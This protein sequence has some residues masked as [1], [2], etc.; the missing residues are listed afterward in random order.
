MELISESSSVT[1]LHTHGLHV[2]PSGR[3]DNVMLKINPGKQNTYTIDLPKEHA[4][5][6]H[7]YHAHLH[8][9]TAVQVQGGMA[10][11]LIVD[12]LVPAEGLNPPG[13]RVQERVMV[14]QFGA[15]WNKEED[16]AGCQ[17]L[18]AA[19]AAQLTP[20][21]QSRVE[22]LVNVESAEGLLT[23]ANQIDEA[24]LQSL[25]QSLTR[26]QAT[27]PAML[28][29][30]VENPVLEVQQD[31]AV[32]RLR[33]VNAGSRRQDY[34]S[35]WIE[36][37][38]DPDVSL[39]MYVGAFDGVNLTSLPKKDGKY[40]AYTKENRLDLAPG[41]RADIFV[42]PDSSGSFTLMMEGEV[43]VRDVAETAEM[44]AESLPLSRERSV[45]KRLKF[46]RSLLTFDIGGA[47]L[48]DN[49]A[50]EAVGQVVE[51]EAFLDALNAHLIALQNEMPAYHDGYLR[52]F[53]DGQEYIKR[54][55]RFDVDERAFLINDRSYNAE[56]PEMAGSHG[57]DLHKQ[58]AGHSD[59]LGKVEGDGGLGP[60]GEKPWPLRTGT[61][62]EWVIVN[63]ST[64]PHPFHIHVSPFWVLD[65]ME[66]EGD[67]LISVLETNPQDPRLNRWQDTINLPPEGSVKVR[68]RVSEFTGV[69]VVH[70][71]IL[72]HEDRG[73]MINIL[74]VPNA[75]LDARGYF[76]QAMKR[77]DEINEEINR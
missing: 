24:E 67:A 63:D 58:M 2:S 73:M 30:G 65:I 77:N 42:I 43:G 39:P 66:K 74:T 41:N 8:G 49:T 3:S 31:V 4:P 55:I 44:E 45:P 7:W 72:Q 62:E 16:N 53:D 60:N 10:G 68:H 25:M 6:T 12:P 64:G 76:M 52:P 18:D 19:Q 46:R 37:T 9:S 11:A 14:L 47:D 59:Y 20:L 13:F 28:V 22:E 27:L 51:P 15:G 70:C 50:L 21:E 40:I 26:L 29:N 34:K 33:I 35:L 36:S 71:H 5:G 48:A 75:E 61:E 69:Y 57:G 32:Q 23:F 54:E 17:G 1:N 38:T 56:D